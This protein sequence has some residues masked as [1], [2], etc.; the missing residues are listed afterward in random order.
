[1]K[2]VKREGGHS[3]AVYKKATANAKEK[4]QDLIKNDRVNVI[5]PADYSKDKDID[6]YVKSIIDNL[7]THYKTIELEKK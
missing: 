6:R 7:A 4:V 2:I 3:I 1:M 5:L